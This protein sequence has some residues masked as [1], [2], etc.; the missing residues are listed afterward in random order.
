MKLNQSLPNAPFDEEEQRSVEIGLK[1]DFA[2]GKVRAN[3]AAYRNRIEDMQR[4]LNLAD[5]L[6]GV[7]QLIRNTADA[8]I[9]GIDAEITAVLTNNLV[10]KASLG[11]VDGRYDEVRFDLNGDGVI[12]TADTELKIPRLAPWSYGGEIIYQ[13]DTSWGTFTAQGSGYRRD[14]AFYT[15]NNRGKLREADMFGARLGFGFR[16]DSIIFSLFGKNLKDEVTIGGDTQLPF[17][18]GATFSPLNK[19]RIYGAEIQYIID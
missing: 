5:P 1:Q 12:D 19:G 18:A 3:L 2:G 15:D 11:Y 9:K 13:R 16:D 8:T 6:A 17:F 14:A 7:V 4:E 10:V